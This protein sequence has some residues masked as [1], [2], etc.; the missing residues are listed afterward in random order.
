MRKH[1]PST[2]ETT[3]ASRQA[4]AGAPASLP[5]RKSS[6]LTR[7]EKTVFEAKMA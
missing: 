4:R 5:P 6:G 7:A 3:P 2:A 1:A